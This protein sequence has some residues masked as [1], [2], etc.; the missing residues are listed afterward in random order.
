MMRKVI[1]LL[2]ILGLALPAVAFGAEADAVPSVEASQ[3]SSDIWRDLSA[4][5][6]LGAIVGGSINQIG[7]MGQMATMIETGAALGV[8]AGLI[9]HYTGRGSLLTVENEEYRLALP[10]ILPIY[11]ISNG[12]EDIGVRATLLTVNY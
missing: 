4:G 2:L 10:V 11:K 3:G 9:Y 5:L 12:Q 8:L 1:T 6:L 7:Q